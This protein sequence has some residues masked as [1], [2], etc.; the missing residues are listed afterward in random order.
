[1]RAKVYWKALAGLAFAGLVSS[2][3]IS[4]TTRKKPAP[5]MALVDVTPDLD[6]RDRM[7][8]LGLV[9]VNGK[10]KSGSHT[11]LKPGPTRLRVGFT[12]PQGGKHEVDLVFVARKDAVYAVHYQ[13]FPPYYNQMGRSDTFDDGFR[14][15]G[16]AMQGAGEAGFLALPFLA[17]FGTG[18][19]A[20]RAVN[21]AAEERKPAKYVDVMVVSPLAIACTVRVYPD[22]RTEKR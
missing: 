3:S 21:S 20:E 1:M 2:C 4:S 19:L 22:G 5:G 16:G 18:A 12:W 7:R 17:V 15:I 13:P 6:N 9:S 10:K 8:G 14:A 11:Q